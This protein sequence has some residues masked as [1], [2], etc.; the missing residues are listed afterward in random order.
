M[1]ITTATAG[2]CLEIDNPMDHVKGQ[3]PSPAKWKTDDG[4]MN[5]MVQGN[6]S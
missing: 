4:N 6:P 2:I 5:P 3:G 1:D